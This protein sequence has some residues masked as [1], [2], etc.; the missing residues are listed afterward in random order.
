MSGVS[1]ARQQRA[2]MFILGYPFVLI[3]FALVLNFFAFGVQ[4]V[5]I[6]LPSTGLLSA[7]VFSAALLLANHT[8]LMTA[9]ELTRVR[10]GLHATPEEWEASANARED[11]PQVGWQ[12]LERHHN[13]HRNATENT[14]YFALLAAIFCLV[15]PPL[16]ACWVWILGFAVGRCGHSRCYLTGRDGLRGLFMSVSLLSLYG[17][18]TYLIVAVMM[19]Y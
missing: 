12:E 14:V 13:A 6:G 5:E 4:P 10:F 7:F 18:A 15:S 17:L 1:E 9:T 16:A 19:T 11:V 8:W 2:R 3:S